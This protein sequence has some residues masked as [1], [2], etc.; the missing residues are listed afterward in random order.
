MYSEVEKILRRLNDPNLPELYDFEDTPFA[1]EFQKIFD[2]YST[3]LKGFSDYGIDPAIIYFNIRRSVNA[4]AC[5]RDGVFI[6]SFNCG[7]IVHLIKAFEQTLFDSKQPQFDSILDVSPNKLM[8]QL[9]L[10]FTL[11]HEMAHLIQDSRYL[12]NGLKELNKSEHKF[13]KERHLLELDADQFSSLCIATHICQYLDRIDSPRINFQ[14]TEYVITI[15]VAA[16][17]VYVLSFNSVDHKLYYQRYYHP[18]PSI[19][20]SS[21]SQTVIDYTYQDRNGRS[22]SSKERSNI[23]VKAANIVQN[24]TKSDNVLNY[25]KTLVE[26]YDGIK[27]YLDSFTLINNKETRLATDKWNEMAQK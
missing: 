11:Y 9:C 27:E 18:H 24:S 8:Y 12:S 23:L 3:T 5:K 25:V 4:F 1:H 26:N 7:T 19:R 15:A 2:F 20:L 16:M 22:S 6:V 17:M 21:I 13:D 10:H 14:L